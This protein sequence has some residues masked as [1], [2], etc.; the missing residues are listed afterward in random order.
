MKEIMKYRKDWV[1]RANKEYK[2]YIFDLFMKQDQKCATCGKHLYSPFEK[3]EL[4]YGEINS[5]IPCIDHD[6]KTGFIRGILCTRCNHLI[7]R[8]EKGSISNRV[9]PYELYKIREYLKID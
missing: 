1:R 6:H 9:T 8:F 2:E 5:E 4:D 7:G 3:P